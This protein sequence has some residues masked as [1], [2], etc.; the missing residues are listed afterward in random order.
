MTNLHARP[1]F[2]TDEILHYFDEIYLD[3]S[4]YRFGNYRYTHNRF[5]LSDEQI[6]EALDYWRKTYSARHSA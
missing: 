2:L 4:N 6:A 5:G 3:G 1:E